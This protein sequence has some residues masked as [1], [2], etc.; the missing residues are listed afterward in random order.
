MPDDVTPHPPAT[1]EGT[2]AKTPLVQVLVYL[3]DR[4]LTGTIEFAHPAG[5]AATFLV[6]DGQPAKARTSEPVAYLGN[7]LLELGYIDD[8]TLNASLAKMATE[9][10]LHGQILVGM[11]AIAQED[12]LAGLRAQLVRKLEHIFDWPSETRFAYYDGFDSLADYGA[13]DS[14]HVDSVPLVW[15]A[16]RAHPPWEHVHAML[17]RVGASALKLAPHADLDRFELNKEERATA[18]LLHAQPMRV[19]DLAA[20]K[21]L[22][23]ATTQ[24]LAYCLLI[25]KQVDLVAVPESHRVARVQLTSVAPQRAVVEERAP[26]APNDPRAQTG[27]PYPGIMS[28]AARVPTV[29]PGPPPRPASPPPPRPSSTHVLT[30]QLEK[31]RAD[32]LARALSIKSEDFFQMLGVARDATP[33]QVNHAFFALAKTW[34]PDRVPKAI[35]DARDACS[36]VFAHLSEAQQTLV[37]PKRREQY[38]HLL[39][40]GGATPDEQAH[41]QAVLE[42]ATNFQKAEFYLRRGEMK[43]AEALCRKA[44]EADPQPPEYGALLA[45][46]EATKPENQGPSETRAK[47]ELLDKAIATNDMLERAYFYRGMLYKRLSSMHRAVADFRKAADLNPRNL[48]ATREVRLFEMR[49][50]RGSIPP[51]PPGDELPPSSRRSNSSRPPPASSRGG[52][53]KRGSDP[54]LGK[55][56]GKLFK[57]SAARS[58]PSLGR[59]LGVGMPRR[60]ADPMKAHRARLARHEILELPP[61]VVRRHLRRLRKAREL[62]PVAE[63]FL[64]EPQHV[65][66]ARSC[67]GRSRCRPCARACG[68]SRGP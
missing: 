49:R 68:P 59:G 15:S 38:M 47:I 8:G 65:R 9:R 17:T 29:A 26:I 36:T 23:A 58:A 34:H 56:F 2:F 6:L 18:E 57:N 60:D 42:A 31:R 27:S 64:L 53:P 12:L 62:R 43:E 35:S 51:P 39:K 24:L 22:G 55:L 52:P 41:V 61:E 3:L 4:Q 66:C 63:V 10:R 37:D 19:H 21:L 50:S 7:L 28:P 5:H 1:A 45:W 67:N 16:V 54:S 33:E 25:T 30:P 32:I 14:V 20:T 11:G 48:E 40:D 13:D 46:I 44:F